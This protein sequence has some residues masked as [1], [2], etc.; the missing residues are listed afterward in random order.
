MQDIRAL[1]AGQAIRAVEAPDFGVAVARRRG[2]DARP[3]VIDGPDGAVI[4]LDRLD[5]A[6]G[7]V[8]RAADRDPVG[9]AGK[10]EDQVIARWRRARADSSSARATSRLCRERAENG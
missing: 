3:D 5:A 8:Q 7:A 2:Q 1:A 4:E 10:G 9:A 6:A